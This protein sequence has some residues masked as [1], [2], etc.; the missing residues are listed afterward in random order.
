MKELRTI[1]MSDV[2][3]TCIENN[4]YTNGDCEAYDNMLTFVNGLKHAS[5]D[6]LETIATDIKEHSDTDYGI[7]GIMFVLVSKCCI[8]TFFE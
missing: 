3:K 4:W 5:T 2:R 1:S 7:A 6:D 8:T